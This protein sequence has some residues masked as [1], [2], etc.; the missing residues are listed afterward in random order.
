MISQVVSYASL[1]EK[2]SFLFRV[3][4]LNATGSLNFDE[5][6]LL[7]ATTLD[8]VA[9][10]TR[11]ATECDDSLITD[12]FLFNSRDT[13]TA[14]LNEIDIQN[15]LAK[16]FI[17]ARSNLLNLHLITPLNFLAFFSSSSG[18]NS[19]PTTTTKGRLLHNN[20]QKIDENNFK[21]SSIVDSLVQDSI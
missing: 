8:G 1:D 9:L 10:F 16:K 13:E 7:L 21:T 15:W 6:A 4:D 3:F 20:I 11:Q 14:A 19:M 5:L 18:T 17:P 12:C 2:V